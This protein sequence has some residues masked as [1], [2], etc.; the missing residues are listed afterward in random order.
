VSYEHVKSELETGPYGVC[1]YEAGNDVVDH[2]IVNIEYEDGVTASM[3]MSA[4]TESECARRTVIQGTRGEIVGDMETF[5]STAADEAAAAA[6]AAIAA[7]VEVATV[8]GTTT[9][10]AY[11]PH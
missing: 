8:A 1:V 10:A 6:A 3:T 11:R 4:F 5:V 9:V 2:Q 7:A